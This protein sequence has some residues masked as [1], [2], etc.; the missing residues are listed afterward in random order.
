[1]KPLKALAETASELSVP[2]SMV[3]KSDLGREVLRC[4]AGVPGLVLQGGGAVHHV[5]GSPRFSADLDF[6]QQADLDAAR[7]AEGLSAAAAAARDA[8]GACALEP[9][10]SKGRLHRQKLRVPLDPGTFH[11]LAIER[12]EVEVH[13]PETRPALGGAGLVRVE[14]AAELIADKLVAAVD[15]FT[16]R[17]MLKLRDVFDVAFLLG[18]G[19]PA[20][21]LVLAKLADYGYAQDLGPFGGLAAALDAVAAERLR[22]ELSGVLPRPYLER[23][24]QQDAVGKVRALYLEL[25]G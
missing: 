7:L 5:Y 9:A 25:R 6:A 23:L 12:Y 18:F 1:M 24:D 11:V 4:T 20:R 22:G 8:W 19:R 3:L 14:S 10:T 15:R 13:E 17:G 16:A 2:L 21:A